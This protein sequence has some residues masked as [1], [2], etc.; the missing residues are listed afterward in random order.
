[1]G[2]NRLDRNE[3]VI[4][5]SYLERGSSIRKL[6]LDGN[7]ITQI[8]ARM[9]LLAS[10]KAARVQDGV[11]AEVCLQNCGIGIIDHSGFNP[12][13]PA[14]DYELDLK[15]AYSRTVL[16]SLMRIVAQGK[17]YFVPLEEAQSSVSPTLDVNDDGEGMN[18]M[19]AEAVEPIQVLAKVTKSQKRESDDNKRKAAAVI[20]PPLVFNSYRIQLPLFKMPNGNEFF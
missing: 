11:T 13:E 18:A 7:M 20:F 3:V 16:I 1:M 17:G 6:V 15:D 19:Y 14:G 8:G 2:Y 4:L 10:R 5:S 9:I 12:S